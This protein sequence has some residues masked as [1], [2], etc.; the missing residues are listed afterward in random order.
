VVVGAAL[1]P[2]PDA[3]AR[4]ERL[5]ATLRSAGLR[6]GRSLG[7]EGTLLTRPSRPAHLVT[8]AGQVALAGEAAGFVSPSSAEG[9]SFALESGAALGA[10][11]A[12]GLDGWAQRY[13]DATARLRR[14]VLAKVLKGAL[15]D[16]AAVRRLALATGVG[17]VSVGDA[18]DVPAGDPAWIRR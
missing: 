6:L 13:A 17:A 5:V 9:I 8:G 10:A 4:F 14:K 7:R 1:E 11:L 16:R 12:P 15:L 3:A 18:P 2:G